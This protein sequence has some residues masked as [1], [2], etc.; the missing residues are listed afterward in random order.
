MQIA[1]LG[2]HPLSHSLKRRHLR[3]SFPLS[4]LELEIARTHDTDKPH[5]TCA[6]QQ[7]RHPNEPV[8]IA[9]EE[10][11]LIHPKDGY[12]KRVDEAQ[13][14]SYPHSSGKE[15]DDT[16]GKQS[17][18]DRKAEQHMRIKEAYIGKPVQKP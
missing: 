9:N 11:K 18:S 10:H 16:Q 1:V 8:P 15:Q 6:Y 2:E 14:S 3:C 4:L 12:D 7:V 13:R 5:R 17:Q